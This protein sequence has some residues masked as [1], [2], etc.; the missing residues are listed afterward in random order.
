MADLE[1]SAKVRT[2]VPRIGEIRI[3]S[4]EKRLREVMICAAVLTLGVCPATAAQVRSFTDSQGVIHI[5]NEREALKDAGATKAPATP[6]YQPVS[7]G[8][9]DISPESPG[10]FPDRIPREKRYKLNVFFHNKI[11]LPN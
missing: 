10:N 5:T 6:V 1:K 11:T 7:H 4:W 2:D 8:F 3:M 9:S